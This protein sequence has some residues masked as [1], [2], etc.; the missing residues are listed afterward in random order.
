MSDKFQDECGLFGVCRH[1]D[2]VALTLS[3]LSAL[4]HRGQ[5]SAGI[6]FQRDDASEIECAKVMGT[7]KDLL[8]RVRA[9]RATAA[10]GHVRYG[11]CGDSTLRNAQPFVSVGACGRVGLCHNGHIVGLDRLRTTIRPD[12]EA[13]AVN[14]SEM[15][16]RRV[17][18]HFT[19]DITCAIQNAFQDVTPAY[20]V[21]V[22]TSD[23]MCAVRDPL[24]MRPLSVGRKGAATVVTS[25]TCA[26]D[27]I[28]ATYV[29]D[30]APGEIVR[31]QD[32][33]LQSVTCVAPQRGAAQCIFELIYFARP[34]SV[35]FGHS[36]AEFRMRLG[37]RLALESP[38]PADVVVPVPDSAIYGGLGYAHASGIDFGM[39]LFRNGLVGRSFIEPTPEARSA[40]VLAK[41]NAIPALIGGRRVVLIDDSIVRGNTCRHVIRMLREAGAREVHIR[42]TSPPVI[43]SCHFGVD[44]PD[45]RELFAH[46]RDV[47]EMTRALGVDSLAFLSVEGLHA[48]AASLQ[49][50]C[51]GCFSGTYPVDVPTTHLLQIRLVGEVNN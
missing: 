16:A 4:Q 24:G 13:T 14:D 8:P 44:T 3:G 45:D 31:V 43:A 25:E 32:E 47:S 6:A 29:R 30:V 49:G 41:L 26:L 51:D 23:S 37:A 46:H 12:D 5:E 17:A 1:P 39:A 19:A 35:M 7:V 38:V 36:V 11:T 21:L 40:A 22:L 48:T 20:S 10:I 27:T 50:F 18:M 42:V 28:G 15:L 9:I 2:A 33:E 34:D